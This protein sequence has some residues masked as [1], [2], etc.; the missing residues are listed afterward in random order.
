MRAKTGEKLALG[1]FAPTIAVTASVDHAAQLEN[2]KVRWDSY[3]RS[4]SIMLSVNWPL[5][6]G[7][8]KILDY[9]IAK[10]KTDQMALL[11]KQAQFASELEVEQNYYNYQ[12]T[13]KSMQSLEDALRSI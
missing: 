10:V 12:E 13:S 5:F 7:G 8:R 4:K 6:E 11:V 3:I 2:A 9:Q 1:Q